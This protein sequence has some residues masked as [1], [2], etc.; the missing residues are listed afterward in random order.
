[1][2]AQERVQ[3]YQEAL[4]KA[5]GEVYTEQDAVRRSLLDERAAQIREVRAAATERV[6]A[7]KAQL[8]TE[9]AAA[10]TELEKSSPVLANEIA[11]AI[12]GGARPGPSTP[13][14]AR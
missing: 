1:V 12:L 8:S 6:R 11:R 10:R 3:A 7:A 2:V 5:R 13:R 9:V 4:R 14:E